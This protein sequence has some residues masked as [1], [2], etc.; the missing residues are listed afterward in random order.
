MQ[1]RIVVARRG[2]DTPG[3][4]SR[5]MVKS[6][7]AVA[8]ASPRGGSPLTAREQSVMLLIML[9]T[10]SRNRLLE[11]REATR[12]EILTAAWDL[13][14]EKGLADLTLSDVG[15]RIGMRAPSLYS[16]FDSR[17]EEHTSE[18]QSLRHLG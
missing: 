17:S 16:Y 3:T 6:T 4:R 9:E 15:A 5:W 8:P 10:P 12:T 11:R 7:R 18:L 14:G 1:S 13:A 2:T